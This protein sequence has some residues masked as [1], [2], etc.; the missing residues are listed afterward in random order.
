[1]VDDFH[2]TYEWEGLSRKSLKKVFPTAGVELDD[3][4][5]I[6]HSIYDLSIASRFQA[7][8]GSAAAK[9]FERDG[10]RARWRAGARTAKGEIVTAICHN[11]DLGRR[12]GVVG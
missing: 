1:M 10:F 8:S 11:M 5:P 4:D 3:S 7:C 9:R 2:G 12:L 6:F